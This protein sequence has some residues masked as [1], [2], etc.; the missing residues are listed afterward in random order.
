[1]EFINPGGGKETYHSA[2]KDFTL[3]M[4]SVLYY[5]DSPEKYIKVKLLEN[6]R[7]HNRCSNIKENT[8]MV[9]FVLYNIATVRKSTIV[10]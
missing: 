9:V 5:N 6:I 2:A 8:F 10:I 4:S 7:K 3:L 1:M